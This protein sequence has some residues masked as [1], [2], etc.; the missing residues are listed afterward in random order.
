MKKHVF[1]VLGALVIILSSG[2]MKKIDKQLFQPFYGVWAN[3][4]CQLIRTERFSILF[5]KQNDAITA[6]LKKVNI[7][8]N[9]LKYN[10]KGVFHFNTVSK[11]IIAKAQSL[12]DSTVI[13]INENSND[14][15]KLETKNCN[16]NRIT[17][18]KKLVKIQILNKNTI[19]EELDVQNNILHV[20][21]A[22]GN[23]EKL[24][25]VEKISVIPK[26]AFRVSE[27]ASYGCGYCLSHWQLGTKIYKVGNRDEIS[28]TT[29]QNSYVIGYGMVGDKPVI[30]A[31]AAR[32]C[33]SDDGMQ[34][35][36]NTRLMYNPIEYT[37]WIKDDI[38]STLQEELLINNSDYH[39]N[40]DFAKYGIFWK[41]ISYNSE[42]IQL[43]TAFGKTMKLKR[44]DA[45][46]DLFHEYFLFQDKANE[47][48]SHN[49]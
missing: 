3:E 33:T 20:R 21:L 17:Q 41:V 10:T 46:P 22:N 45:E 38:F 36:Q 5:N 11:K 30:H 13:I 27:P 15:C 43:R 18:N 44:P 35:K 12:I 49:K 29:P 37:A 26:N 4:N 8:K 9:T 6:T 48:V 24:R 42:S 39:K 2:C 31:R 47:V 7:S 19:E 16:I 1:L 14:L 25:M 23:V 28:I 32:I 34:L 40:T